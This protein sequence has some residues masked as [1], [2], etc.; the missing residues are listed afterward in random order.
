[1]EP[2][3]ILYDLLI[4]YKN[5]CEKIQS[6]DDLKTSKLAETHNVNERVWTISNHKVVHQVFI[7]KFFVEKI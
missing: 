1:L 4:A 7:L 2:H 3:Y 6:N 5:A